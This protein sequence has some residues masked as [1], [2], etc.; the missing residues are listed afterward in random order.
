MSL[1]PRTERALRDQIN[2]PCGVCVAAV[3]MDAL[4][5]DYIKLRDTVDDAL[6]ALD[7]AARECRKQWRKL[8]KVRGKL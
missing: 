8:D 2:E 5:K 6:A 1:S 3:D 7:I 4:E